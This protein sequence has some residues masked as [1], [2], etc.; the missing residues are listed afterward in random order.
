MILLSALT[1][2]PSAKTTEKHPARFVQPVYADTELGYDDGTMEDFS[3]VLGSTEG[4]A[5]KFS[6]QS[7]ALKVKTVRI[8]G[9]YEGDGAGS[10]TFYLLFWDSALK[11]R[12]FYYASYSSCFN[13][14]QYGWANINVGP[15]SLTVTGD[16]YIVIFPNSASGQN[17]WIGYDTSNPDGQSYIAQS[18]IYGN[19]IATISPPRDWMIRCTGES[20]GSLGYL[21]HFDLDYHGS[22][23]FD[24]PDG[25]DSHSLTVNPYPT[26]STLYFSYMEGNAGNPYIIRVYA[27]WYK[28]YA[29]AASAVRYETGGAWGGGTWATGVCLMPEKPGTYKIRIVYR[30]SFTPPTWDSYDRLLGEYTVAVE[31]T[32]T[33]TGR[34]DIEVS[35]AADKTSIQ[36]G[37][38]AT[39]TISLRNI[40]DAGA[41]YVGVSI[42]LGVFLELVSGSLSWQYDSLSTGASDSRSLTVKGRA[43][44]SGSVSV[45]VAY[46]DAQGI[47]YQKSAVANIEVTPTPPPPPTQPVLT[48]QNPVIDC[49]TVTMNGEAK[50]TTPGATIIRIHW[51]WGDGIEEDRWFPASHTYAKDGT[52]TIAVRAYDS[53][54]LITE[55]RVTVTI[56]CGKLEVKYRGEVVQVA[57]GDYAIH[58]KEVLTPS[59]TLKAGDKTWVSVYGQGQVIGDVKVGSYVE[60]YGEQYSTTPGIHGY[61]IN[62]YQSY[63]YIKLLTGPTAPELNLSDPQIDCRTVTMNGEAKAT[64]PGATIIRIHWNWG[65]GIEEDRWF[66]AS[67]TYA[68]DG[69]YT[70]TVTAYDSNGLSTTKTV[71]VTIA[72]GAIQIGLAISPPRLKLGTSTIFTVFVHPPK[73]AQVNV[74]LKAPSGQVFKLTGSSDS[75]G[76]F[77]KDFT[78]NEVGEWKVK[79]EAEHSQASAIIIVLGRGWITVPISKLLEIKYHSGDESI[80]TIVG[81]S[82]LGIMNTYQKYFKSPQAK[83][84]CY[85]S[86]DENDP[87]LPLHWKAQQRYLGNFKAT[88]SGCEICF[89]IGSYFSIVQY[90]NVVLNGFNSKEFQKLWDGVVAHEFL[91]YVEY[92]YWGLVL[93][94]L[95]SVLYKDVAEGVADYVAR[96]LYQ[97]GEGSEYDQY[98]SFID[99]VVKSTGK[100]NLAV[101]ERILSETSKLEAERSFWDIMNNGFERATGKT[102]NEWKKS[103]NS[104]LIT[105]SL[106]ML[107]ETGRKLLLHVY[108]KEGRHVGYNHE[109][110]RTEINIPGSEYYDLGTFILIGLPAELQSFTFMVDATLAEQDMENYTVDVVHGDVAFVAETVRGT[111]TKGDSIT[112][113]VSITAGRVDISTHTIH[114]DVL[115]RYKYYILLGA[116][117][118]LI[119]TALIFRRRARP[120]IKSVTDSPRIKA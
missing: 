71:T 119:V 10:R 86:Y 112:Y 90:M 74:E 104:P 18:T 42:S 5:V 3:T 8:Y 61:Q 95:Y 106:V 59:G 65:D 118:V 45:Q 68:K 22:G 89:A 120:S 34:P 67:H 9:C 30:G 92:T 97:S 23:G 114:G 56:A 25:D 44:G 24:S 99:C 32:P 37:E 76:H 4:Y 43:A 47:K 113:D 16:F 63:H 93:Y 82:C 50:A 84:I 41:R 35:V 69:T 7:S 12:Q 73:Q 17:L 91:H 64:T 53:N 103:C 60:V 51:N 87:D 15:A 13:D 1:I 110:E 78:P 29:I 109:L 62:V 19:S 98:V 58:V 33:P 11:S 31:V 46:T 6:L 54:G 57:A 85:I 105:K 117:V 115:E 40:G 14:K 26:R 66:P 79:A 21:D 111:A 38:T 72:C 102:Y 2:M 75:I 101:I 116:L 96:Q 36:V 108:D 28:N 81:L 80:A 107:K 48:L 88:L 20:A 49:R 27:E 55:K 100:N 70:V 83:L 39:A 77:M 52:Y 94:H